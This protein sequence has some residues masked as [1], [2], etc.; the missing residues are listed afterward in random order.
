MQDYKISQGRWPSN[1][2]IIG[3]FIVGFEIAAY[4][5]LAPLIEL[6]KTAG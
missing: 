6:I 5:L 1:P 2:I 3:L 4:Y